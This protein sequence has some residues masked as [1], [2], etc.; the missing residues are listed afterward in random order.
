MHPSPSIMLAAVKF[1]LGQDMGEEDESEDEEEAANPAVGGPSRSEVYSAKH[2][3]TVSSKKKKE[4][5]LKRVMA[6]LKKAARKEKGSQ[7]E[8]FAA[9]QLLHDPQGKARTA[10]LHGWLAITGAGRAGRA[11]LRREACWEGSRRAAGG[12]AR[13]E[14]KLALLNCISRVVGGAPPPAPE[15][16]PLHS[17]VHPAPPEGRNPRPGRPC[18]GVPRAGPPETLAPVVK[19]LVDQFVNDRSRPE[20]MTI[21]IKTVRELCIRSPLVMTPELLQD[22]AMYKKY[23][24][25][26]VA[27]A[28][29][30]LISLFRELAPA[31]LEKKDR[32]RGADLA[33][34]PLQYGAQVLRDRVEGADLLEQAEQQD[35]EESDEKSEGIGEESWDAESGEEAGRD[36]DDEEE[37]E[38]EVEEEEEEVEREGNLG[39]ASDDDDP[40]DGS[41]GRRSGDGEGAS[42]SDLE[43]DREANDTVA[44]YTAKKGSGKEEREGGASSLGQ[45]SVPA[46]QQKGICGIERGGRE[47][48]RRALPQGEGGDEQLSIPPADHAPESISALKKALQNAKRKR[49]ESVAPVEDAVPEQAGLRE[50]ALPIEQGRILTEEDFVRIRELRHKKLVEA[51][52]A[53]HGL[54]SATK[55]ARLEAL[56]QDEADEVLR[57]HERRGTAAERSVAPEALLGKHKRRKDKQER[58]RSVMEGRTD[59]EFGAASG[60]RKKKTGGSS[61]KQKAKMKALPSAARAQQIRKRGVGKGG[62]NR[63]QFRGTKGRGFARR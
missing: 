34:V 57:M 53:K 41:E 56:A 54:K 23:R 18:P 36:V 19:Q 13:F 45:P 43:S 4:K 26:E 63:N 11:G 14:S 20:V 15:P 10:G 35:V 47:L 39:I 28:A 16:V 27:T 2:K 5:K 31:M 50:E 38:E 52:M 40:I 8:G 42:A 6:T 44:V 58:M 17:E 49:D 62:K 60:R 29:R 51:A 46:G 9:I 1:F 61:N 22:L 37:E 7:Q 24:E 32:G 21:G 30:G 55:R 33:A 25:K 48:N 12:R 3:G 59:R